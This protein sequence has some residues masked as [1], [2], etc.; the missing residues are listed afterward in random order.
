MKTISV[1]ECKTC[2]QCFNEADE[3]VILQPFEEIDIVI[4]RTI[5]QTCK[6]RNDRSIAGKKIKY[7]DNGQIH[8]NQSNKN[9]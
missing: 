9:R 2:G 6:E 7:N 5:C 3:K 8:P 1:I 4:R